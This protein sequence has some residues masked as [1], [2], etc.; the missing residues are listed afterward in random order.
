MEFILYVILLF[1]GLGVLILL[2]VCLIMIESRRRGR[3]TTMESETTDEARSMSKDELEQLPC[4]DYAA[5]ESETSTVECAVCLENLATGDKCRLLPTC[6]HS[7]H[8][9]C[10]DQ[11]LPQTPICPICRASVDSQR[12]FFAIDINQNGH[13]EPNS[14]QLRESPETC[15]TVQFTEN[16]TPQG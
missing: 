16:S 6:K 9:H 1:V 15:F 8:A 7:F 4:Y 10:L 13:F 5:K 11:W 12:E 14:R 3:G 2:H